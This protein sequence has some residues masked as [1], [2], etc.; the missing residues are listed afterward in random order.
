MTINDYRCRLVNQILFSS[1]QEDV[2]RYIDAAMEGLLQHKVNGHLVI[3]FV[4]KISKGLE[5]LN[6]TD[7]GAQQ[8]AN[9]KIART[10]LNQILRSFHKGDQE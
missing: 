5:A 9:V 6:P 3:R 8:W 1:S 2:K 7:C 10:Q 4:E